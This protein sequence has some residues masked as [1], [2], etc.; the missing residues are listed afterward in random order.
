MGKIRSM[1]KF[2]EN[3]DLK[4]QPPSV[5][6]MW[7]A[8]WA[9]EQYSRERADRYLEAMN[10][11]KDSVA[12][13]RQTTESIMYGL[14][15]KMIDA[16]GVINLPRKKTSGSITL[17]EFDIVIGPDNIE[18]KRRDGENGTITVAKAKNAAGESLGSTGTEGPDTM[19]TI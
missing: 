9:K 10:K 17:E 14:I 15:T 6:K 5:Y 18:I 7:K 19:G 2:Q 12:A 13:Y 4:N 3:K 11:M 1:K 16:E 8:G